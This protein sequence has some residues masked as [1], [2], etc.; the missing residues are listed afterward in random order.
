MNNKYCTFLNTPLS[1][2]PTNLLNLVFLILNAFCEIL[3]DGVEKVQ[4]YNKK[5]PVVFQTNGKTIVQALE[6]L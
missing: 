1:N 3:I 6:Q 4:Y 2:P 5:K